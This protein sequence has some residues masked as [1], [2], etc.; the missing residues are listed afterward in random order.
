MF[1]MNYSWFYSS[2]GILLND[3]LDDIVTNIIRDVDD[4]IQ[5]MIGLLFLLRL[6]ILKKQQQKNKTN[7]VVSYQHRPQNHSISLT[8]HSH[9]KTL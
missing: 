3:I 4:T 1:L 7:N 9:I 6:F 2:L 5:N 8:L